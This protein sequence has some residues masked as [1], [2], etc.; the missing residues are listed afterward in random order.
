MSSTLA[1]VEIFQVNRTCNI[2]NKLFCCTECCNRHKKNKHPNQEFYCPLCHDEKFPLH[3]KLDEKLLNHV[4]INHLPL[5]CYLCGDCFEQNK[6]FELYDS[7]KFWF[8]KRAQL[9]IS[10]RRSLLATPVSCCLGTKKKEH[11]TIDGDYNSN[12]VES[13]TSPPQLYRTTSTPMHVAVTSQQTSFEYKTPHLP[14]FLLKTPNISSATSIKSYTYS[15]DSKINDYCEGKSSRYLTCY[16][17]LDKTP[18][19]SLPSNFGV[20]E[21]QFITKNTPKE[22][23][24][25]VMKEGEESEYVTA[26]KTEILNYEIEKSNDNMELTE[27]QGGLLSE[28]KNVEVRI[29][30][31]RRSNSFKKVRFSD[32]YDMSRGSTGSTNMTGNDEYYEAR[33]SLSRSTVRMEEIP[34]ESDKEKLNFSVTNKMSDKN[35]NE[36]NS[37]EKN[38]NIEQENRSYNRT[39]SNICVTQ[40]TSGSSRVVMMVIVED[41]LSGETSNNIGP[42]IESGLKELSSISDLAE[43]K[44]SQTT[45]RKSTTTLMDNNKE[46]S[47]NYEYYPASNS[48]SSSHNSSVESSLNR[49]N[50][51]AGLF[52]SMTHAVKQVFRSFSGG[53]FLMSTS[54]AQMFQNDEISSSSSTDNYLPSCTSCS[55]NINSRKRSRDLREKSPS[56][57]VMTRTD[58][59]ISHVDD[60]SPMPK[61]HRGWYK[62]KGREPIARMKNQLSS[63]RGISSE[64]Q[65]FSQGSL[66]VGNTVIPIPSR[67]HQSVRFDIISND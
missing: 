6:D 47:D 42:L 31:E 13:L 37:D 27:V 62:I 28:M 44:L 59:T 11:S 43:S 50:D 49:K 58:S 21:Q 29:H 4:I 3:Q 51:C 18:F 33:Q 46:N 52:S 20:E 60:R 48:V 8:T 1:C 23:T 14:N 2:C 26:K 9:S 34:M 12:F 64:T 19:R 53:N 66:S 35:K 30:E 56:S 17:N 40:K 22:L 55:S 63:P 39:R 24:L 36:L 65:V 5:Y 15:S 7:C 57:D 10:E 32:Q 25:P 45:S 67:A 61:R 16:T 41:N 54:N 38:N